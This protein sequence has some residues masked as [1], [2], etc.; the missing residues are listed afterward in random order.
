MAA[1]IVLVAG[2]GGPSPG[3]GSDRGEASA[4]R[5]SPSPSPPGGT[6]ILGTTTSTQDSGLLDTLV[7]AYESGSR[8][9]VKTVA[10]GSGEALAM[11]AR[12]DAD[13]LLVHSPAAEKTYMAQ[14]HGLSRA[15]VMHNDFVLLGPRDD[16]AHVGGPDAAAAF[17][18]DRGS[19][20]AVRLSRRRLGHQRQGALP[21][22]Q[23]RGP[24]QRKLVRQDRPGHGRDPDDRE[25]EAGLHPR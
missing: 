25:P 17:A 4:E 8:C 5:G 1:A 14:G 7:P 13:V 19:P 23:G 3:S 15:A 18:C 20:G 24:A 16:P 9:Q 2:C 10:V 12:G 11:G 21:V 22:G 6:L